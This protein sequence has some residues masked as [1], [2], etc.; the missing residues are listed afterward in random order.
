[1]GPN[2]KEWQKI[3]LKNFIF[4]GGLLVYFILLVYL[5]FKI[6]ISEDETYT[7][8]TSSRD[9][10]G[11]IRQSY[12]FEGQPPIYFILLSLWRHLN[13]GIFFAKLFSLICIGLSAFVFYH[14]VNY[15]TGTVTAKWLVLIFLLNPFTV[16]AALE[17]RVYALLILLSTLSVYSFYRYYFENNNKFLYTLI[18]LSVIGIYTQYFFIFLIVSF[19]V[20]ILFF[21]GW[22]NFFTFCLY[23]L[24]V[25]LLFLP[26]LIFIPSQISLVRS[27]RVE[28][29]FRPLIVN[30]VHTPQDLVLAMNH[31]FVRWISRSIR[32]TFYILSLYIYLKLFKNYLEHKTNPFFKKYNV[33]LFS[34]PIVIVF[35][36]LV[37]AITK[38]GYS[39]KYMV[40]IFPILMLLLILFDSYSFLFKTLIYTSISIYFIV[41]LT[42]YYRHPTKTYDFISVA[43]YIKKIEQPGE[44]ILVYR[45]AIA[46][47]FHYYYHGVN[48]IIPIP[49]PV[50]FDSSYLIN[51][52]D[53]SEL[54]Q[55][56]EN[57]KSPSNSYI[58]LSDT[59]VFESNVT[60][61][62]KMITKFISEHY[63]L[64]LDT[65]YM[66]WGKEKSLRIRKFEKKQD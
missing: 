10:A 39:N 53:T 28:L 45:P 18:L 2:G 63:N 20:T 17:M 11:I 25:G 38:I 61:N 55:S 16:W 40:T 33:V 13:Q 47:P 5:S 64:T 26:N 54:R 34:V 46:L 65:L 9:L 8:N 37:F 15:F 3:R 24:P 1:M 51:I 32:L 41:L 59:T 7:L 31:V 21:K 48:E 62:R 56:I 57:I 44:P 12:E 58:L 49:Y 4:W 50:R 27:N 35:F 60:M 52:K 19:G 22:K 66:G 43:N 23:L 36:Y 29:F 42:L 30:I 14:L 6:N